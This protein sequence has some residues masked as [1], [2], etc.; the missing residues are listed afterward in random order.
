MESGLEVEVIRGRDALGV[1]GPAL[2][3]LHAAAGTPVTARRPWLET[4]VD[5]FDD[6]PL[7]V[8]VRSGATLEAAALLAQRRRL[9]VTTV[10]AMGQG[11]SDRV[12]F[13][14][15]RPE[16]SAALAERLAA[17]LLGQAGLWS[18]TVRHLPTEDPVA[19]GLAARLPHAALVAGDPSPALRFGPDRR[20]RAYVSRNH[21]QQIRQARNRMQREGLTPEFRHLRELEAIEAVMPDVEQ[22]CRRRDAMLHRHSQLDDP[23]FG[24]FFRAVILDHAARGEV[25]LTLLFLKGELAAYCLCFVDRGSYRMWN[26]RFSPEWARL[27][28]G[29]VTNNEAL[30]HG[31]EDPDCTEFDWMLGDEAYKSGATNHVDPSQNLLA[32]SSPVV[33]AALD[34]PRYVLQFMKETKDRHEPL[35][36]GWEGM[37]RGRERLRQGWRQAAGGK[38]RGRVPRP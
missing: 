5:C 3:D 14:S 26:C 36:R 15:R 38:G 25:D 28:P 19:V 6:E 27:S 11:P 30:A 7:V 29:R 16:A 24:P 18:L 23:R 4:W 31:L 33:R 32:W 12:A 35:E 2:D 1:V 21:H 22:V 34:S 17:H 8:A 20:L 13:P 9:G 37:K 10:V